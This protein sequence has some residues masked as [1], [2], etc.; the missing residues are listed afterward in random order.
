MTVNRNLLVI[1]AATVFLALAAMFV[2]LSVQGSD[3]AALANYLTVI[4][5]LLVPSIYTLF[6]THSDNQ[7]A[8]QAAMDNKTAIEQ[9]E[10]NT[11]NVVENTNGKLDVRFAQVRSDVQD[12]NAKVERHLQLH[13][14]EGAPQ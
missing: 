2:R 5:P 4:V 14:Q 6:K 7:T 12:L 10:A 13:A 11:A 9:V 3:S 1:V 8:A